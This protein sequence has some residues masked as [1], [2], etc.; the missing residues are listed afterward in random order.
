MAVFKSWLREPLLH[1]FLLGVLLFVA[2]SWLNPDH[3]TTARSVYLSSAEVAWLEQGWTRQWQRPPSEQEL[4][5]L[6]ADYLKETLLASEA[7]ELGLDQDDVVIRRRLAQK[8]E[9]LIADMAQVEVPNEAILAQFYTEH[10]SRYTSPT[11]TSFAQRFYS[12]ETAARESL[13]QLAADSDAEAGEPTLLEA[14]YSLL[15]DQAI[16]NIFGPDFPLYLADLKPGSW[17]GPVSSAYGSHLVFIT[18][19]EPEQIRPLAEVRAQVL[20]DWQLEQAAKAKDQFFADLM[21]KYTIKADPDILSL[22]P[23]Q[24]ASLP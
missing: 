24:L 20:V 1:F 16:A 2:Y 9:F 14:N 4:R 7:K 12:N 21:N 3:T 18:T 19:R 13:R 22:L 8:M 6:V 5:G 23:E 11:R 17:Q 10:R 15:D